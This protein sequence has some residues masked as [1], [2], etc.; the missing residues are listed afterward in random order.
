MVGPC[1]RDLH[2]SIKSRISQT[3][4]F[5]SVPRF[6]QCQHHQPLDAP[7]HTNRVIMTTWHVVYSHPWLTMEWL[8]V[9]GPVKCWGSRSHGSESSSSNIPAPEPDLKF[10]HNQISFE[11]GA[12][13][14]FQSLLQTADQTLSG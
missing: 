6:L 3:V 9:S 14:V 10:H 13:P 7:T 11:I 5:F 4:M 1:L 12:P 8:S 2:S